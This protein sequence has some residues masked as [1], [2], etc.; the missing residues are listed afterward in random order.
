VVGAECRAVREGVGL[1]DI[2][3]FSRYEVSGPNAEAWLNSLFST[4]LPKPGRARLAV[5]LGHDGRLKGDLTLFNWGDGTWWI[6]GSYYLRTWHMR[7]FNDHMQDGVVVRDLGEDV[8]GFSLAGPKSRKVIEKLSEDGPVGALPFMGCG[9][10]DIGLMRCKVGRMSVSGELG[11]EIHCRM[12]DHISLRE[13]LLEAGAIAGDHRIRLQRASVAAAGEELRH[14][15]RGVHPRL[16]G[17]RQTGMDRWINWDKGDFIG[18]AALAERD[19]N[20]PAQKVVTLEVDATDADASGFEPVWKDGSLVGF[21]TSG[22]Y[23]H[24]VGKSLAM[25]MVNTGL[26]EPGTDLSVHIVGAERAARVIPPSPYDPARPGDARLMDAPAKPKRRGRAKTQA[27]PSKRD[28]NYR[29]LRN[30]FPVMSVFSDDE[31]ANMHETALRMLEELGMRVL[32]PEARDIFAAG[33]ARVTDDDM[34]HIGRDMVEAALATAPKSIHCRAGARASGRG[35]GAGG[36]CVPARRRG[37]PRHG[38][39]ARTQ[40]RLGFGF[41]RLHAPRASFRRLPDDE[42]LG[43]AAGR[44]DATAA[45]LHDAHAGGADRQVPVPL[46]PRHAAGP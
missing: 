42:P 45:L 22:G 15:E 14:L 43:R 3:G 40:A 39:A 10:F 46:R 11:Y 8:A 19:G 17:G 30:P 5:A 6:M 23:G 28:V 31:A 18:K 38:S 9:E 25:A 37:A 2:S 16:H 13:A 32:L 26:T 12:G 41:Q 34:V 7:W 44:A 24:T 29:Q 33:G 20:G 21:V 1:L 36:D 4:T 27:A 35:A